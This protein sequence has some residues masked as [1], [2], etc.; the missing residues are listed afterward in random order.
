M[1]LVTGATGNTGRPVVEHL[2]RRGATV[3]AAVRSPD[4]SRGA[5]DPAVELARLDLTDPATFVPAV[6]GARAVFLVRPP[7]ISDVAGTLNAFVDAAAGAGVEHV[8]FLSVVGAERARFI[9]HHGV[10]RHLL[11]AGPAWTFLRAGFF[12]QNLGDAY[13]RDIVER[14]RILLPAGRGRAAF[15]DV[16]DIAEVAADALLDGGLRGE[17]PVLTGPEALDFGA[18]ARICGDV[19]GRPIRYQPVSPPRYVVHVRRQGLSW[20]QAVVQTALHV[21]LRFG[22]ARVDPTLRQLLGRPPRGIRSYL[23]DHRSR[24]RRPG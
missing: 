7:A 13:R 11:G 3:R 5:F 6:A 12:A 22:E 24:F 8:A 19:L 2:V 10:E 14:D 23:E 4:R 1:I 9:P 15:V 20:G 16:R 18:V 21:A 17:A